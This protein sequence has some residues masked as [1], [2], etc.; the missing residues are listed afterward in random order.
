MSLHTALGIPA[1]MQLDPLLPHK[2]VQA[3]KWVKRLSNDLFARVFMGNVN[4]IDSIPN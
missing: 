4:I 3:G 2:W 1:P